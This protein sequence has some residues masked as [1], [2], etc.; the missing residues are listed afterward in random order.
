MWIRILTKDSISPIFTTVS[1]AAKNRNDKIYQQHLWSQNER[2]LGR[3]PHF[4]K[5]K[6]DKMSKSSALRAPPLVLFVPHHI[7][8][9]KKSARCFETSLNV[10]SHSA[11]RPLLFARVCSQHKW[12]LCKIP[13]CEKGESNKKPKRTSKIWNQGEEINHQ[14]LVIKTSI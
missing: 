10:F 6:A 5:R 7:L 4:E 8:R 13:H 9:K 12:V 14:H 1:I 11:R 2:V 3:V